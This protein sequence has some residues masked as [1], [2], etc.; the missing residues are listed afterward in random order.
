MPTM[1]K[2]VGLDT[3]NSYLP[4]WL[5]TGSDL[6]VL[7]PVE[8][9][10]TG[11]GPLIS[12]YKNPETR[13]WATEMF[14]KLMADLGP[15]YAA[16]GEHFAENYPRI[17]AHIYP[18]AMEAR[19][20][21]Q[22]AAAFVEP[23]RVKA[24]VKVGFTPQGL[25]KGAENGREALDQIYHEGAHVAQGLGNHDMYELYNAAHNTF[26]YEANP[27]EVAARD[28]ADRLGQR[29]RTTPFIQDQMQDLLTAQ[30]NAGLP[31]D[32][33]MLARGRLRVPAP[34]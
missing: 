21:G 8:T 17:A 24:P 28:A 6:G 34:R 32:R 10:A 33:A 14:K 13:A 30:P 23:G 22:L 18:T 12:I 16:A 25:A 20:P 19:Q 5:Q 1:R 4:S 29:G 27:F 2:P 11:V 9:G 31:S 15:E 3:I 26:G 7:G